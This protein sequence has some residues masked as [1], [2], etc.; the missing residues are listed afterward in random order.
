MAPQSDRW[1]TFLATT[2]ELRKDLQDAVEV[3]QSRSEPVDK[4]VK[5]KL[6]VHETI[7]VFVNLFGNQF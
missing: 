7:G 4:L 1:L 6:A 5:H 3:C 2:A